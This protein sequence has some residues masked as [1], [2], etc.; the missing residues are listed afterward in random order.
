MQLKTIDIKGKPYVTVNERIKAFRSTYPLFSIITDVVSHETDSILFKASIID[1]QGRVLANGHAQESKSGS[2][3]NKTSYVENCETSAIGRALGAFGIGVDSS[4][5]T[6]DEIANALKNQNSPKKP[7]VPKKL[8]LSPEEKVQQQIKASMTKD[9]FMKA[10]VF[11][12]AL[13]KFNGGDI[14]IFDRAESSGIKFTEM[15][16]ETIDITTGRLERKPQAS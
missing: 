15:Q 7:L 16:K 4:F 11:K 5:A 12:K 8:E 6:A 2:F 1:D 10:T 9:G 14:L 3:I 13:Q